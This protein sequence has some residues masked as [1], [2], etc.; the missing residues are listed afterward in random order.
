M[1]ACEA[2]RGFGLNCLICWTYKSE[3]KLFLFGVTENNLLED[4]ARWMLV[5]E[6]VGDLICRHHMFWCRTSHWGGVLDHNISVVQWILWQPWVVMSDDMGE[7]NFILSYWWPWITWMW[8]FNVW[9]VWG[10]RPLKWKP[11]RLK[12]MIFWDST[13]IKEI[14]FSKRLAWGMMEGKGN[15]FVATRISYRRSETT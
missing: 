6:M 11:W 9:I 8:R 5:Y 10:N 3:I 1:S 4:N 2:E 12:C 14:Y 7:H 15:K 13:N